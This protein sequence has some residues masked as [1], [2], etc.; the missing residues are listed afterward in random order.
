MVV[1]VAALAIHQSCLVRAE[2]QGQYVWY[3][4]PELH[5]QGRTKRSSLI[6]AVQKGEVFLVSFVIH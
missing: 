5:G 3:H 1:L 6:I 4:P 2:Q